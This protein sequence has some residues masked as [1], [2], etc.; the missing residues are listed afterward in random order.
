MAK[1][2][3]AGVKN[4]VACFGAVLYPAQIERLRVVLEALQ[5]TDFLVWFDRDAAGRRGQEA[6]VK[7]L[8]EAGFGAR[9]FDWGVEFE[10]KERGAVRIADGLNDACDFS[11]RQLE[12][13][14][15]RGVI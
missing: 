3:E 9:G 2:R 11:V 14:R 7:L 8:R 4:A 6:A 1:L 12:F 15:G 5:I 10:S 13:L